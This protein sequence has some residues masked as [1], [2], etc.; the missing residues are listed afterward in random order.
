M[1][2]DA[3]ACSSAPKNTAC[4]HPAARIDPRRAAPAAPPRR[5][6]PTPAA[7]ACSYARLGQTWPEPENSPGLKERLPPPSACPPACPPVIS[8][9]GSPLPGD[10]SESSAATR[11][12]AL[13]L[14]ETCLPGRSG[15]G[16]CSRR[17]DSARSRPP[18]DAD[19]RIT[20][21]LSRST[22]RTGGTAG[23]WER[24][25]PP[26]TRAETEGPKSFNARMTA[27]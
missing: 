22:R 14:P 2:A 19:Q 18:A 26:S 1:I 23:R 4:R 9:A 10:S 3:K 7:M 5:A 21:Q 12:S 6:G 16:L 17:G 25:V 15:G 8:G 11:R 27:F 13:L 20:T 24:R